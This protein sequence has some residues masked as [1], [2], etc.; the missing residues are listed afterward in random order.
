[1]S[2]SGDT[3]F[4]ID[5]IELRP[6]VMDDFLE[7]F[8]ARYLPGARDRGMELVHTWVTPPE[9]PPETGATILFVWALAGIPGFWRMRSQNAT[10]EIADWW[11][12]CEGYCVQRTRRF[13]VAPESLSAFSAAGRV[14]A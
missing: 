4:L 7:A 2:D 12:E 6:D 11:R 14:H 9:T 3:I 13:A 5:E 8:R 10:P 1:M